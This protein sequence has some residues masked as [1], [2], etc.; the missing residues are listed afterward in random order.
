VASLAQVKLS[1][2]EAMLEDCSPGARVVPKKHH[3]W[4]FDAK[5]GSYKSLP[6]G[7]HGKKEPKIELGH[8]RSMARHLGFE[9]CAQKHFGWK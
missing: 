4:V 8:V 3:Y 6:L 9:E 5:G 2:I 7:E 1:A